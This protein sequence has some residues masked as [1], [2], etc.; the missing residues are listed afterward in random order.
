M[1]ARWLA[2]ASV[3]ALALG[4][5]ACS[6]LAGVDFGGV[7]ARDDGTALEAGADDGAIDPD[8]GP[9]VDG[10]LPPRAD[11]GCA[12]D[13]KLCSGTCVKQTDPLYGCTATSCTACSVPLAATA[14]CVNAACA[15]DQCAAGRADCD[16]IAANGCEADLSSPSNCGSANANVRAG[17]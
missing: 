17:S 6:V 12:G 2:A 5:A 10:A 4:S 13:E 11:G 16:G 14:K 9:A 15:P 3:L 1:R 8:A 7:H